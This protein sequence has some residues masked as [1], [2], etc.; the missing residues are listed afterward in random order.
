MRVELVEGRKADARGFESAYGKVTDHIYFQC[1]DN[2]GNPQGHAVAE[3]VKKY[4]ADSDGAFLQLRY[5]QVED[6]YYQHWL[7]TTGGGNQY[8]HLCTHSLRSCQR[9]VGREGMVHIQHWLAV[10]K[11]QVAS[12]TK[13]WKTKPLGLGPPPAPKGVTLVEGP[14]HT[15]PKARPDRRA[16]EEERR[17]GRSPGEGQGGKG[18]ETRS[19]SRSEE[20]M[21]ED[22]DVGKSNAPRRRR[23]RHRDHE[24]DEDS[25]EDKR[26]ILQRVRGTVGAVSRTK[27]AM[28]RKEK[29]PLD[30]MLEDGA[31]PLTS[32]ADERFEELRKSLEDRKRK[33]ESQ[34]GASAV[35][36][37]RV[38]E[39]AEAVPKRRKKESEREKLKEV[40]KAFSKKSKEESSSFGSET[41][42]EEGGF[43][44]GGSKDGE[45]M[46]KQKRLKKLS[47][48]KP[49]SLLARG[50]GLMHEQL[51]TLFGDKSGNASHEDLLQPAALRYLLSSALP[52]MDIKKVGEEK[53]RELRTLATS[54]DYLVSGKVGQSG[55]IQMQRMKS[56]L[57][58]I[59]DGTTTASRYLELVPI[60]LYPTAATMEEADFARGLA[61]RQ[62]RSEQLL[63]RAQGHRG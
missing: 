1:L 13:G 3:V 62:A 19:P 47:A 8:H 26:G 42:D 34:G 58:G 7:E 11:G 49:G 52:L 56:I 40:L 51:G 43:L 5:V 16:R 31:D 50:F 38:Q 37:K 30:A 22:D 33:H 32:K 48:A 14:V 57:M 54:L 23:R 39:G 28:E 36:A 10:D 63:E 25:R 4:R 59:K 21:E 55:D 46:S 35:L 53:M 2:E 29:T 24:R 18:D 17:C 60:E 45:L 61:V 6:Q 44:H 15:A 9:K 20:F 41:D 27:A 12:I